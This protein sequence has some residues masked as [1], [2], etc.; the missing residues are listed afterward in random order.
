VRSRSE[1]PAQTQLQ[2]DALTEYF[3]GDGFPYTASRNI[4]FFGSPADGTQTQYLNVMNRSLEMRLTSP[5]QYGLRWMVGAF[6]LDTHRFI[7]SSNGTDEGLGIE[8]LTRD[9]DVDSA[10]NPTTVWLA[11]NNHNVATALFG[12]VDYDFSRQLEGSIGLRYDRDHRQQTVDYRQLGAGVPPGCTAD[13]PADCI[14]TATYSALQP[15]F[16]LR[17][18]TA[19]GSIVYGSWGKGF[20][21]GLFNQNGVG[22]IAAAAQPPIEGIEDRVKAE[23]T[24][25]FEL[26]YK[27]T[28]LAG[29]LQLNAAIFDSTVRNTP[30][31][32]FVEDVN[33]QVIVGIDKVR[34][35]GGEFEAVANLAPGLDTSAGIGMT[36]STIE[37][38]AVNPSAVGNWAP[39]VPKFS[40]N[41]GLQYRFPISA[42]LRVVVRSDVIF[43]G[44]QYW[45]PENDGARSNLTLVNLRASIEDSKDQ[46][47]LSAT[48]DNATNRAYNAEF[49]TG[50]FALPAQPRTTRV[51]LRYNF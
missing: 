21:S 40:G 30:Y 4:D 48:V 23:T 34:L 12:D 15:K 46:W 43:K 36:Q 8:R 18:K 19:D 17:F 49:V 10:T 16:S 39:Y 14:N 9:P 44:K 31:F 7:S 6:G 28:L 33:A 27:T 24:E 25:S 1:R 2:Q 42:G 22:A 32:V 38:Y 47:S 41:A 5:T 37:A 29:R 11:D 35:R 51:A 3:A 45:D 50:G 26:G 20:R 13:T